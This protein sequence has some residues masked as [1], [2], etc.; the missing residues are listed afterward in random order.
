MR[1]RIGADD[2]FIGWNR[3]S[4]HVGDHAAG[5]EEFARLDS[6]AQSVVVG[7]GADAHDDLFQSGVAGPFADSVDGPFDLARTVANAG[8]GVGHGKAKVVVA[9]HA[10]GGARNVGNAFAN[11]ANQMRHTARERCSP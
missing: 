5:A 7:A 8:Q 1:E 10:D 2:G 3:H 9:V 4:K 6:G 11:A